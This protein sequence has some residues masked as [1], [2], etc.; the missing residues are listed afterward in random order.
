MQDSR[1]E[2]KKIFCI[3]K[4]GAISTKTQLFKTKDVVSQRIIKTVI[5]KYGI[6]AII[7]AEKL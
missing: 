5:I 4:Y 6:Y 7:F 1:L 3:A 2:I